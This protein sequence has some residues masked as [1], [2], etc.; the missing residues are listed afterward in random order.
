VGTENNFKKTVLPR[1]L[2]RLVYFRTTETAL[3]RRSVTQNE[4]NGEQKAAT[5]G[6]DFLSSTSYK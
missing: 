5:A 1:R 3:T 6:D 2:P 4:H